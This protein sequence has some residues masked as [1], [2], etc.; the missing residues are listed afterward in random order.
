LEN[1]TSSFKKDLGFIAK[2]DMSALWAVRNKI[3]SMLKTGFDL[4]DQNVN[5]ISQ[6]RIH[7]LNYI[8]NEIISTV[9]KINKKIE[10]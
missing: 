4:P 9:N 10:L 1:D 7:M 2:R 6:Q 8:G 5:T 3:L